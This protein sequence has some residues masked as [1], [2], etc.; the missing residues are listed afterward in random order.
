MKKI[1]L[2]LLL[3]ALFSFGEETFRPREFLI[4]FSPETR[5]QLRREK[6]NEFSLSAGIVQTGLEEVDELNRRYE[7]VAARPV[8]RKITPLVEKYNLDLLYL[9]VLK[10]K[11]ADVKSV[12][13]EYKTKKGVADAFPNWGLPVDRIPND[14]MFGTQWHLPKMMCPEA[15]DFTTGDTNVT[16]VVIDQGVDYGHRDLIG[17][18]WVNRAEDLNGN[19]Q[20]DTFPPPE[21]DLDW[22]DQDDNG[23]TDDVIGFDFLDGDPNPMPDPGSNHGTIC[24][25]IACAQTNNGIGVASVGWQIRGMNLRCGTGGFIYIAQAIAGIQYAA[26]NG[27]FAISN[28]WGGDIYIPQL[29]NALQFAWESGCVL[30]GSAGNEYSRGN[31]RYPACYDR[32]IA[33]AASDRNDWH[34]VWGGGQQSNYADWVDVCAPGS[35]VMT[36]DNNNTYG[37][38]DGTSMSSPCVAGLAGLMKSAFPSLTNDECTTKIFLTCDPMPDTLYQQGL[39]GHGRI[40]VGKAI[41]SSVWCNLTIEDFRINDAGGNNNGVPEPG[42]ICGLIVTLR[43]ASGWQD[44]QNITAAI[45]TSNPFMEIIKSSASFPNIP[46]GQSASCSQDSFVIRLQGNAPPQ[47]VNFILT[48]NS[49]PRSLYLTENLIVTGGFPRII[50]VDDDAGQNY[51][52]WYNAACDSLAVLYKRWEVASQG[53]PPAETL[54]NYPVVIWWTGLDSVTS[55]TTQERAVL[56]NYLDNRGKLFISGA[57]IGQDIGSDPFYANYLRAEYVANHSGVIYLYGISGDPIGVGDS[58]CLGGSGGANNGRTNDVINPTNGAIATHHYRGTP[59]AYGG[60]RYEGN[61]KLVYFAFPFEAVNHTNRYVQKP[62]LL[63]R[64]L[65]YFGEQLPYGLEEEV[66]GKMIRFLSLRPNPFTR[67]ARLSINFPIAAKLKI[68]LYSP[69][70]QQIRTLY[71]GYGKFSSLPLPDDLPSGVYF[72]EVTTPFTQERIKLIKIKE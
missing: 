23:Y 69:G 33:T 16:V 10:D 8:A 66:K 51:E 61:Y 12:G 14:P 48:K 1:S 13:E 15:W 53:V 47:R 26:Q 62:E 70:G 42:E 64:I 17:S 2:F 21:G 72:L 63:R 57:N 60:I 71:S 25:G 22:V 44:A 49:T 6:D 37:A 29:N 50:L 67:N 55:L 5:S 41:L 35:A 43:N 52:R 9:F 65:L 40:N 27:A 68:E 30:S 32:V 7:V 20:F 54:R 3:T 4:Q 28:S 39:L 46:A 18:F 11:G 58:L 24:H 38:Y 31:P 56:T 34:S 36:T 59:T 45:A 19:G